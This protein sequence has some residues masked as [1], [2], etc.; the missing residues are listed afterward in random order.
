MDEFGE[1][2]TD[3]LK[4]EYYLGGNVVQLAKDLIGRVLVTNVGG[5]ISKGV[6]VETEAYRGYNDKASHANNGKR[7]KRNEVMYEEGGKAY[8]YLC[9]G[10]HQLFNVVTNVEGKADAVL[11]RALHPIVGEEYMASR[12]PKMRNLLS[13]G[14]GILTKAMGITVDMTKLSLV[15]NLIWLEEGVV[16]RGKLEIAAFKRVGVD[17]AEQDAELPW[18]FYLN[19]NLNVSKS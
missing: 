7:T 12:F 16:E 2:L 17:Y 10:I 15:G 19:G 11:I 9:Y 1:I 4:P 13:N 3:K 14:P 5:V 6:I 18:R 8:V